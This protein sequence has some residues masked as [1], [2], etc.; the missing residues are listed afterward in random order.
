MKIIANAIIMKCDELIQVLD[1]T[2]VD[3]SRDDKVILPN[4][5]D[6]IK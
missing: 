6:I 2:S 1:K 5:N 3:I 4:E